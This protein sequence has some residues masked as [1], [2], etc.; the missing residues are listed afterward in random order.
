M[1]LCVS[2]AQPAAAGGA[3]PA[4]AGAAGHARGPGA[5]GARGSGAGDRSR[6]ARLRARLRLLRGL[7]VP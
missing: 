1:F 6:G 2:P 7:A 4:G 3:V 5:A